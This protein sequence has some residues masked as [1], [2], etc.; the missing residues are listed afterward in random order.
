MVFALMHVS[1][2]RMPIFIVKYRAMLALPMPDKYY[3]TAE[4]DAYFHVSFYCVS[5]DMIYAS[6]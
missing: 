2:F 4:K 6:K 5:F 1:A 3:M